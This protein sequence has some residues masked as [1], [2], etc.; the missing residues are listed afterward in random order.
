[1]TGGLVRWL[2]LEPIPM[3]AHLPNMVLLFVGV[4]FLLPRRGWRLPARE[5]L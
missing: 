4:I 2:L 1:V 3:I 5:A